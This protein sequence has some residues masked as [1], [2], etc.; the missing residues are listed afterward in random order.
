LIITWDEIDKRFHNGQNFQYEVLWREADGSNVNWNSGRVRSPPFIVNNTGTY[1]PFEIKVRSV[2]ALGGGPEP[3][4]R[5]GHSGEDKPE[6]APTGV[7]TTVLNSTI[8]EDRGERSKQ[9][10]ET[11]EHSWQVEEVDHS[12]TSAEVTGLRLF[13]EYEL[14]ITAFNSK[15]ESPRSPPHH[16]HTPEGGDPTEKSL[17]LSWSHPA[18]TNGILLGYIVQY[19]RDSPVEILNVNDPTVKHITLDNLDPDSHY[20]FKVTACTKIGQGPPITRRGAT[21][22]GQH[23]A[24]FLYADRFATQGWLIGLIS[25]IVLLVLILLILCLIK[26]SKGG[27]Y[28]VKDKESKEV[29]SE[30]RPMKDEAF[31]EYSDGDE[32]RSDSQQSLE[33]SKMGSVDSLAEYGDSVD[34][35]FNEDGS[36]IGQYSGRA[37]VPHG[38]ESSG[39][40]SP[41]NAVPP[42][43]VAPSMSSI[44]NRPS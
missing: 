28:A 21:L 12:K 35:Q 17:I 23:Y 22:T 16:F 42:P 20:I 27:K 19:Q 15:G 26:R 40:A 43:P 32:K 4:S 36:F 1:T 14:T 10:S 24:G 7:S 2:N 34:I 30:A 39:P 41:V 13:S 9:L 31:G 11:D 44:L 6:E 25:A 33:E 8:R 3:K 18:E 37:S 5:N 38:N 29:D